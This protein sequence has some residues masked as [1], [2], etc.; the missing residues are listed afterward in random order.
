MNAEIALK[1]KLAVAALERSFTE[2]LVLLVVTV[3][4]RG[5][6]VDVSELTPCD[7]GMQAHQGLALNEGTWLLHKNATRSGRLRRTTRIFAQSG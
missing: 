3:Q 1:V 6:G 5:L 4:V 2:L 7:P